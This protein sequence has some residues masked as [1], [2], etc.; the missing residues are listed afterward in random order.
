MCSE[1]NCICVCSARR[2]RQCRSRPPFSALHLLPS[3]ASCG[4]LR[5][6]H[7]PTINRAMRRC[8]CVCASQLSTGSTFIAYETMQL[9]AGNRLITCSGASVEMRNANAAVSRPVRRLIFPDQKQRQ[10]Y[11]VPTSRFV[12]L[13]LLFYHHIVN[14][15]RCSGWVLAKLNYVEISTYCIWFSP[16]NINKIDAPR[17]TCSRAGTPHP[18]NSRQ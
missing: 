8:V 18:S 11:P 3:H 9:T 15:R 13:F 14:F 2:Y 16:M 5:D 17:T 1:Y 4:N 10:M 7:R 6:F 12:A